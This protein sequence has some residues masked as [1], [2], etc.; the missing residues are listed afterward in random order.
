MLIIKSG[1]LP[2]QSIDS[3]RAFSLFPFL[4][5]NGIF[6]ITSESDT[7]YFSTSSEVAKGIKKEERSRLIHRSIFNGTILF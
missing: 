7:G 2:R 1:A 6:L 3:L 4:R 5:V